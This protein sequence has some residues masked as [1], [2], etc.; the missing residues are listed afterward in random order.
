MGYVLVTA[1]FPEVT[2]NQRKEIYERL[3]QEKWRKITE[4]GRDISTVWQ[5]KFEDNI[6]EARAKAISK[7]DFENC[8]SPYCTPKLV[9]HFGPGEP[10]KCNLN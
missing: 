3:D 4:Y 10:T 8:S 6:I 5:A 9:I 1:D 7:S 2:A